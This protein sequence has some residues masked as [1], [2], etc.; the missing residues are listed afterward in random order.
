MF[1]VTLAGVLTA[2]ASASA[3]LAL[4]K[5]PPL[6]TAVWVVALVV[7][8]TG[9]VAGEVLRRSSFGS[10][11]W[12]EFRLA[13]APYLVALLIG[14]VPLVA[15]AWERSRDFLNGLGL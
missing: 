15:I 1:L 12:R 11:H 2:I 4:G 7:G 3:T 13:F 6:A 8:L 10:R 5:G 14:L 9:T